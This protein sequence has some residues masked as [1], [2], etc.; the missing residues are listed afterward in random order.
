MLDHATRHGWRKSLTGRA[1]HAIRILLGIQ[2]TPGIV[3]KASQVVMLGQT[4]APVRAVCEVLAQAE[5]LDDDRGASIDAWFARAVRQLPGPM[6]SELRT[7]FETLRDGSATAPRI[8]PRNP[9]TIRLKL[10]WA[11]PVLHAWAASGY[12]SLREI[13]REQVI[14]ALPPSG[15]PRA[16]TGAGLR[17]VF[18]SSRGRRSSSPTRSRESAPARR[19]P[20]SRC[21]LLSADCVKPS[22]AMTRCGLPPPRCWPSAASNPGSSPGCC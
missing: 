22:R 1:R 9:D 13:T 15:T 8:K 17:S 5:M 4:G 6:A 3:I 18:S 12:A 16:T 7:W 20:G 11:L 2:D 21:P 14:I 10:R 19:R